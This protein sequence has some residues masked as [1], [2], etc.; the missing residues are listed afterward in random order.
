MKKLE[1]GQT[2]RTVNFQHVLTWLSE[3]I[4]TEI[5]RREIL[6]TCK[7]N[8]YQVRTC[9]AKFDSP[10]CRLFIP[11]KNSSLIQ[12]RQFSHRALILFMPWQ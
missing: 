1:T 7:D 5:Y 9:D 10:L 2:P 3:N 11:S 6:K 4:S 8:V 12:A